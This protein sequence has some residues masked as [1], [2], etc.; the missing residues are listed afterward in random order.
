ML[1]ADDIVLLSETAEDLQMLI[2]G[3]ND[4]NK[5][6]DM[7]VNCNKS[8]IV[9]FRPKSTPCTLYKFMCG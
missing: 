1:Y 5:T 4:W 9:H 3:V 8:N 2:N 6:N 7:V